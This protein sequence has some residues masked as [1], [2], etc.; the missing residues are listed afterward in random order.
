MWKKA[1]ECRNHPYCPM[2]EKRKEHMVYLIFDYHEGGDVLPMTNGRYMTVETGRQ[3]LQHEMS[4]ARRLGKTELNVVMKG[5]DPTKRF[6]ELRELCEWTWEEAAKQGL[7]VHFDL[8][9]DVENYEDAHGGWY[10]KNTEKL[11]LWAR[12]RGLDYEACDFAR[13][14]DGG[15]LYQLDVRYPKNA[16]LHLLKIQYS[17]LPV[18][19]ELSTSPENWTNEIQKKYI[20]LLEDLVKNLPEPEKLPWY[21]ELQRV[22]RAYEGETGDTSYGRC[23]DPNGWQWTCPA[24]SQLHLYSWDMEDEKLQ[25]IMEKEPKTAFRWMCPGEVL[26]WKDKKKFLE[27]KQIS[28]YSNVLRVAVRDEKQ[29]AVLRTMRNEL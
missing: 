1:P 26:K 5:G 28:E 19:I 12:C 17:D 25:D 6:A 22:E 15:V 7:D 21:A 18:R 3:I 24:L 14:F 4:E 8:T 23:Y 16:V 13:V 11:F 9:L 27:L 2:M 20:L 29:K 10:K